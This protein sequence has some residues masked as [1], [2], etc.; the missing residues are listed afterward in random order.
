MSFPGQALF[1]DPVGILLGTWRRL[2]GRAT[3][4]L[5]YTHDKSG[6][7]I[8][9]RARDVQYKHSLLADL[10]RENPKR[11]EALGVLASVQLNAKDWEA[12]MATGTL[13]R[14]QFPSIFDGYRV[15]GLA[16]RGLGRHHESEAMILAAMRRF[17]VNARISTQYV[18]C[19]QVRGDLAEALRRCSAA[20]RRY[21]D[22]QWLH[23]LYVR[24]AMADTRTDEAIDM[25]AHNIQRWP[26]EWE[27]WRLHFN[28]AETRGD[29]Q[30]AVAAHREMLAR[31]PSRPESYW[32]GSKALRKAGD[33]CAAATVM[34]TGIFIFPRDPD[35][36]RERE[37]VI[38]AGGIMAQPP[39]L[40]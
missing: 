21:P 18:H 27:A 16:L 11:P 6:L 19:A 29:W 22:D 1:E 35:M 13:L 28:L 26:D 40:P 30:S 12:A 33:I 7:S 39:R 9:G 32:F 37:A 3:G 25:A 14:T 10:I 5:I 24:I 8:L 2:R 31:F 23:F 38:A 17:P 20:M 4:E 34:D 15:V 36:L